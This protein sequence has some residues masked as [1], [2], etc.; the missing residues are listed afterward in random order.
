MEVYVDDMLVKSRQIPG[1]LDDDDAKSQSKFVFKL[2]GGV[3]AW[4]SSEQDAITDSTMKAE[5]TAVSETTKE[6]V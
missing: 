5:Y 2:N 6:A 3:V 4:K 1:Y